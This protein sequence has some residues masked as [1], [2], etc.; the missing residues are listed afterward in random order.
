M[1]EIYLIR[2]AQAEGNL[3]RMMQGHW[4][5]SVTALGLRQIDALAE[6][7]RGVKVDALYSSDLYRTR[8]TASAVTRYHALPMQLRPALREINV[9]T[10]EAQFFG[11]VAHDF[12]EK[13]HDFIYEPEKWQVPGAES[14][15]EVGHRAYSELL[16]IAEENEGKSVVVVSHGVTILCLLA[17]ILGVPLGDKEHLPICGNTAVTLLKFSDGSFTPEYIGDVSHLASLLPRPWHKTPDLRGEDIDPRLEAE[18]YK[19]CYSDAWLAAHGSLAGFTAEPYL[20]AAVKHHEH[21]AKAVMKI[22]DKETPAGLIDLDT[23]RGAHAG[24]GWISL[25]YLAPEYRGIGCG[26]QLLGR[27]IVHYEALN[28]RALRLHVAEDNTPALAFYRNY[29][30][31]ELSYEPGGS[32]SRLLLMEKKIGG[33][34]VS[35]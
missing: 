5:G 3:Y 16:R 27:A 30:F 29:G 35:V 26:I 9:G 32:G 33:R 12:P 19:S 20:A 28:R 7:F 1:T 6:R 13:M 11:D 21:D 18:F 4:D 24:Y 23:A 10:W 22:F 17:K 14:Y 34:D 31:E 8:L 15:A 25:L 2:H